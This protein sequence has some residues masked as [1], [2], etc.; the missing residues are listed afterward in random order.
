MLE[1]N[2]IYRRRIMEI[3]LHYQEKGKG[4]PLIL[5]HGNGEDGTYFVHQIA[6][7]SKQYRVIAVDNKGT[8]KD[9]KR[10]GTFYD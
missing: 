9:T 7:F 3:T 6:Y 1:E 8:W 10:H 5:L 2:D 4:M